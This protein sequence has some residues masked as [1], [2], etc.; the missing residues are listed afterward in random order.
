MNTWA[1]KCRLPEGIIVVKANNNK[2]VSQILVDADAC[3]V[4]KEICQIA[5]EFGLTVR[6]LVS[7]AHHSRQHLEYPEV[8]YHYVD[9]QDQAVDLAI[10][11]RLQPGDIVVTQ[12]IGLAAMVL[13]RR[14]RALTPRGYIFKSETIG[15][16][17]EMR[18][19]EAKARQAGQR[20]RG[21]KVFDSGERHNFIAAFRAIIKE[22]VNFRC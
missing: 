7:I 11:N 18:H 21:P 1:K 19:I 12:D 20:T 10:M 16:L 22:A 13:G 4:K 9:N 2:A 14:G 6:L 15:E 17:L 3:P 8:Y 5:G